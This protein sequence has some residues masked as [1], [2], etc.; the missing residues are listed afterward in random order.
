MLERRNRRNGLVSCFA[1]CTSRYRT[2]RG[3]TRSGSDKGSTSKNKKWPE[4]LLH[5]LSDHYLQ[6][7]RGLGAREAV[8][9]TGAVGP[10]LSLISTNQLVVY[11]QQS[12]THG[13]GH[14]FHLLALF[15]RSFVI[16]L[17]SLMPDECKPKHFQ[18]PAGWDCDFSMV[19][20]LKAQMMRPGSM[21]IM[22][23]VLTSLAENPRFLHHIFT[24]VANY[25][26][27]MSTS[28][29]VMIGPSECNRP[30]L[31]NF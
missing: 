21:A 4:S 22:P 3:A 16:L 15:D 8:W 29:Q 24:T 6:A 9:S 7:F 2:R 17:D 20:D 25:D 1:G 13:T 31:S 23:S 30:F 26:S 5:S 12:Q 14:Q 11:P 10:R 28:P 19:P 18:G 27:R